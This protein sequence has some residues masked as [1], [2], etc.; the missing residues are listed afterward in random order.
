MAA[1]TLETTDVD[2]MN[3]YVAELTATNRNLTDDFLL[4]KAQLSISKGR[5]ELLVNR[6][7]ELE[8]KIVELT[9]KDTTPTTDVPPIVEP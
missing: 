7:A 8:K 9:P 4:T 1:E 6:I 5:N 2:L 3:A